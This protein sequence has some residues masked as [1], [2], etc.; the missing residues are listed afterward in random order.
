MTLT[1]D[2]LQTFELKHPEIAM[3]TVELIGTYVTCQ[4]PG[5][6]DMED[7]ISH[8]F[9]TDESTPGCVWCL[10]NLEL[11]KEHHPLSAAMKM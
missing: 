2:K 1:F 5:I 4:H 10:A 11:I 8:I 7:V 3:W 6:D 9:G